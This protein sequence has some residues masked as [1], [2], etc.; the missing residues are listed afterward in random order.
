M[1]YEID[2]FDAVVGHAFDDTRDKE[3]TT[4]EQ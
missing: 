3:G 1:G 4:R 2:A